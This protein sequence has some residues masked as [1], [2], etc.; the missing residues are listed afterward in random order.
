MQLQYIENTEKNARKYGIQFWDYPKE[1][2]I[3]ERYKA[4]EDLQKIEDNK[5][6]SAAYQQMKQDGL[7]PEDRMFVGKKMNKDVGLFINDNKG[8]PRIKIYIDNENNPK[9]EFLNEE[10]EV[11]SK[12]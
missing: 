10:G 4:F 6:K 8:R 12:P 9:M 11:M 1:D 5:E 7:L 3:E 2:G